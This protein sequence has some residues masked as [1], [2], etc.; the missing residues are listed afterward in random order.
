VGIRR[1]VSQRISLLAPA[2]AVRWCAPACPH[3][4]LAFTGDLPL[5]R[6]S[7]S[8]AQRACKDERQRLST[9]AWHT[10]RFF[11]FDGWVYQFRTLH[12]N[13]TCV[14]TLATSYTA[15]WINELLLLCEFSKES[16]QQLK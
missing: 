3:V 7:V 12:A 13:L 6:R 2:Y 16:S 10:Q 1:F 11:M 9:T 15:V 8:I 4:F 14:L 5:R